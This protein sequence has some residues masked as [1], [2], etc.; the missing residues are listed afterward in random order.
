MQRIILFSLLIFI[1]TVC[2]FSCKKT[3]TNLYVSDNAYYPLQ[4][5]SSF[6]YRLDSTVLAPF[7]TALVVDSYL[8]KDSI[9]ST[10]NDDAGRLSYRVY[11]FITDT[12]QLTG[13]QYLS[14]YYITPTATDIEV[15]DDNNYRFIK[16]ISPVVQGNSWLGNSFIDTKSINSPVQFMDGWNYT[17]QNVNMPYTVPGGTI[18]S[19]VTVLQNEESIPDTTFQQSDPFY[20]QIT[21]VEV[22]AKGIGLIY[23]NFLHWTWQTEPQPAYQDGSY[24]IQLSLISYNP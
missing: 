6:I 17:Y 7:G 19:T 20:E 22:Y 11:R 4:T 23:K 5:G 3:E 9:E 15:M 21:A 16:L 14:T 8:L 12:L 18:D 1:C 13:W 24:G 2:F 10:F